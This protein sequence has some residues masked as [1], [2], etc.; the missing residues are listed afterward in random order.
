MV[1]YAGKN[2][3]HM[4]C[5]VL[6]QH[7]EHSSHYYPA[8]LMPQDCCINGS[9][10]DDIN[11]FNLPSGGE[12]DYVSNLS[13]LVA[14]P[15][16]QQYD[17]QKTK[18]GITK[19]PIILGLTPGHSLGIP[20]AM[21]TDIMHLVMNMSTL[22]ISLWHGMIKVMALDDINTWHWAVLHTNE[23]WQAHGQVVE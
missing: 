12:Q 3:C 19:P 21:T 5:G 13:T 15:N 14:S 1:G 10:H 6:G 2:G 23:C 16:V 9:N 20:I 7:K 22:L 4:Y 18:T 11:V 17:A 8:L